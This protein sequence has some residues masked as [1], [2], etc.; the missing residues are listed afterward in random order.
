MNDAKKHAEELTRLFPVGTP[1]RYW[2]GVRE[3]LGRQGT[4]RSMW[5][6]LGSGHVAV[7]VTGYPGAIAE[8][9]VECRGG[10]ATLQ[11]LS[12]CGINPFAVELLWESW[13]R[14][15]TQ[16]RRKLSFPFRDAVISIQDSEQFVAERK[17]S[18]GQMLLMALLCRGQAQWKPF[19]GEHKG[20]IAIGGMRYCTELDTN[21]L[22]VVHD[23]LAAALRKARNSDLEATR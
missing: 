16:P 19:V 13:D 4:I 7:M 17:G 23:V 10:G 14:H 1:C 3:G 22:P 21:G 2:P 9:H 20:E 8:T 15:E 12:D 6:V 5:R 11:Q 18:E